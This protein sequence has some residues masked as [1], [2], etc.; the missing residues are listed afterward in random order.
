MLEE[1]HKKYGNEK[2]LNLVEQF[3]DNI[4][5]ILKEKDL[6]TA[7][8][9]I[10][11]MRDL[12]FALEDEGLGVKMELGY[13]KYFDDDFELMDWKDEDEAKRL[14]AKGYQIATDNPT[15]EKMRP[16]ILAL[17]KLLPDS[18]KP[19]SPKGNDSLLVR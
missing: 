1:T 2:T 15:K 19:I 5:T 11:Q 17:F 10:Q 4:P 6:R 3:R 8:E 14:I 16:L 18:Q 12:E 13:L 7:N 9:L